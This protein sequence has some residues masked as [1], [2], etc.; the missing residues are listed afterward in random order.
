VAGRRL[1]GDVRSS[2]YIGFVDLRGAGR[3][4]SFD[5]KKKGLLMA[6]VTARAAGTGSAAIRVLRSILDEISVP[7]TVIREARGRRNRVLSIAS[8]HP[9]VRGR[10]SS[11][12]V[13]YGTA[14]SPLEDA[15]GGI[16]M[17]R[18]L[19]D[20]REFGPDAPGYGLGP[21]ELME[22]FGDYIVER[23]RPDYPNATVDTTGKRAVKFHFD[24]PV[25]IDE[26]GF[27]VDPYVDFIIGLAR[28][29]AR[30]LWIPNRELELGWDVADPEYHLE[31]MNRRP[32]D[33]LRVHRAHVIRLAKRAI[34]RDSAMGGVAVLCSW[35][36]SALALELVTDTEVALPD[37]LAQFFAGASVEIARRL[38]PD[39][40]P[41]VAPIELPD[42]TSREA[43]S[44]RLAEMAHHAEEA[45]NALSEAGARVAYAKLYGPEIKAIRERE[46]R[47]ADR[48]VAAGVSLAPLVS[49]SH[50]PTRSDGG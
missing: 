26:L 21:T 30:G 22:H 10:Y 13:A 2:C 14:N 19:A 27:E 7:L 3:A 32:S 45:A 46:A 33:A 43:A 16:K 39:P 11:G 17:N 25:A 29:N 23:L 15:D 9:A 49:S 5:T 38:T 31:V 1:L 18:R 4:L 40:S 28:A 20:L 44:S 35:N 48:T 6:T 8:N 36:V 47:V 37:A 50:K 12:S 42:G 24:A 34:K 41:V